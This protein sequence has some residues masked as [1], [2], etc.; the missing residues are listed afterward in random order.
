MDTPRYYSFVRGMRMQNKAIKY[1][2]IFNMISCCFDCCIIHDCVCV[3]VRQKS[4]DTVV[5]LFCPPKTDITH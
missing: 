2:L 4:N 1:S 5:A 3:F